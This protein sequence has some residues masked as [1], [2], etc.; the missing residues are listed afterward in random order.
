MS[1]EVVMPSNLII[2][3]HP[4]LLLPSILPSVRVFSNESGLCIRWSFSISPSS[5][6]SGLISFKIDWF[7]LL[8]VQ[9]TLKSSPAPQLE[10]ISSSGLNLL[11]V[12]D[13]RSLM[14]FPG[15]QCFIHV[16]TTCRKNQMCP[17]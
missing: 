6:Y 5:E 1:I 10:S 9:G 11:Y 7:D 16:A 12:M 4:L 17:L 2:L 8:V 13:T 3:C 15:R 14:N